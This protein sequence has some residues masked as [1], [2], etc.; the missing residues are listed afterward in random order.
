[1]TVT[2]SA[3]EIGLSRLDE[4]APGGV[5]VVV[6]IDDRTRTGERR[7]GLAAAS[8]ALAS[9]GAVPATVIGHA[10]D[11]RPLWPHGVTG[12]IS[13]GDGVAVAVVVPLGVG[14]LAVG[15]DVERGS[16]LSWHDAD[17]VLGSAES[18]IARHRGA[19]PTVLWS[20]KEAA[21]KAWS[22]ARGAM[23]DVDPL[24][25]RVELRGGG[26]IVVSATGGLAGSLAAAGVPRSVEGWVTG[27]RRIVSLV[28]VV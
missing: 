6:D 13:H 22:H 1:M 11:G 15:V 21:F 5:M 8:Q 2:S 9:V 10:D 24:D 28:R 4:L 14:V 17:A 16:A 20:A 23:P 7:A 19:D 25:M 3:S 12:S 26:R 27:T 18:A